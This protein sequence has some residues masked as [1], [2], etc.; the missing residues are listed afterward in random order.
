[1]WLIVLWFS[2]ILRLLLSSCLCGKLRVNRISSA[3]LPVARAFPP[4]KNATASSTVPIERTRPIVPLLLLQVLCFFFVSFCFIICSNAAKFVLIFLLLCK[5]DSFFFLIYL[6]FV[7]SISSA[8]EMALVSTTDDGVIDILIVRMH[9]TKKTAV[10]NFYFFT[11]PAKV[12][13]IFLS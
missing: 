11:P 7:R 4:G 8:A 6:Q 5:I 10:S 12:F 9:P 3:A 2:F 13:S 1:M